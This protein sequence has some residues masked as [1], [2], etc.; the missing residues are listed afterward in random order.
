MMAKWTLYQMETYT[1]VSIL[2]VLLVVVYLLGIRF[3]DFLERKDKTT[4]VHELGVVEGSLLGLFAFFLGF[5]FN[6]SCSRFDIRR[7]A[8]VDEANTI[9]TAILRTDLFPE[10]VRNRMGQHFKLYVDDRIAYYNARLD[11][12]K[13]KNAVDGSTSQFNNLWGMTA[14]FVE[15]GKYI[16]ASRQMI[17]ALNNMINAVTTQDAAKNSTVPESIIWVMFI[18]SICSSFIVGY[19]TKRGY[20]NSIA[21]LVLI[22]MISIAVFLIIDLDKP[23]RGLITTKTADNKIIELK[24]LFDR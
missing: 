4:N 23:R 21:G 24:L 1:L 19:G 6:L 12:E 14:Q 8:I 13:I 9:R 2:F 16:E 20:K 22:L 15:D 3:R 10:S 17:L 7:Q 5:T 18:L 11:G